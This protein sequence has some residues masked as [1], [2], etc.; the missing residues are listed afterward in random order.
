M[1][2]VVFAIIRILG[3]N[4]EYSHIALPFVITNFCYSVDEYLESNFQLPEEIMALARDD[5]SSRKQSATTSKQTL[6]EVVF[7]LCDEAL[8]IW[9]RN[10]KLSNLYAEL[11]LKLATYTADEA[12]SHL[13]C[14]WGEGRYCNAGEGDSSDQLKRW[15]KTSV[16]KLKF[17]PLRTKDGYSM[18]TINTH[19]RIKKLCALLS[20]AVSIGSLD[21][22]TRVDVAVRCARICLVGVKVR[23]SVDHVAHTYLM[24]SPFEQK[25]K[26]SIFFIHSLLIGV[27]RFQGV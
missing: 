18:I 23:A 22:P 10:E 6:P 15:E 17:S 12:E 16:S 25:L 27:V 14:R 13:R 21:T 7:A 3:S 24:L 1:S 8:N 26:V 5:T 20:V 19:N 4:N 2:P 11:L 9:N